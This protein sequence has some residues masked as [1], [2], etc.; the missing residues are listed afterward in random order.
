[1]KTQQ[2]EFMEIKLENNN[3]SSIKYNDKVLEASQNTII[4]YISRILFSKSCSYFYFFLIFSSLF[5]TVISLSDYWLNL[6]VLNHFWLFII[7][8]VFFKLTLIDI[9]CRLYA[10]V[11]YFK[12]EIRI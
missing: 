4:I 10:T 9:F 2:N 3:E 12:L 11:T 8:I 1:M 5:L 6:N 7:E